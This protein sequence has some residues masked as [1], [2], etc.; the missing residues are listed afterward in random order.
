MIS[1]PEVEI[2]DAAGCL[3]RFG[4]ARVDVV[5]GDVGLP[6]WVVGSRAYEEDADGE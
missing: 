3:E 5:D 1:A 2:A 6:T 4:L